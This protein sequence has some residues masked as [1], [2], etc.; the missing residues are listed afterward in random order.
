[1]GLDPEVRLLPHPEH[2][3]DVLAVLRMAPG[4]APAPGE[5]NLYRAIWRRHTNRR[6]FSGQQIPRVVQAGMQKSAALRG[7]GLRMLD[8]P[9]TATVLSLAAQAG[10]ELAADKAHQ[11]EL[12]KWIGDGLADGIPAWALP[13]KARS[14]PSPVR[15]GDLLAVMPMPT[16]RRAAYEQFPQLAVLTT[17]HDEPEDW[18]RAGE[19]LEHVLLVATLN[20]VSASFLFQ[21]IERDDM[22]DSGQRSWPWAEHPQMIIRL[23]YGTGGIPTPRRRTADVRAVGGSRPAGTVSH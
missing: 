11:E 14:A 5:R 4:P 16:R 22:R 21:V 20:N 9:D 17:E 10:R 1:V 7:A 6:P 19:A 13:A 3:L 2:P 18:L 15:D 8:R 23:G 12:R